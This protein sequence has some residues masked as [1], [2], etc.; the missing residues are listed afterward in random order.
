MVITH[1]GGL[2]TPLIA[3]HEPP[4]TDSEMLVSAWCTGGSQ[5]SWALWLV[6]SVFRAYSDDSLPQTPKHYV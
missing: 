4:S 1:I 3:T 5:S 6:F 2:T